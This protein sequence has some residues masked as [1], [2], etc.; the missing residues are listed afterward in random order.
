MKLRRVLA[1][2]AL[3]ASPAWADEPYYFHKAGIE[4]ET[5]AADVEYCA[6]LAGGASVARRTMYVY[7]PSIAISAVGSAI[8]SLFAGM[9]ARA[10]L[11][12]KVSR[13]ERTCMADKGYRRLALDKATGREMDKL[14]DLER[15]DRMFALVAAVT[16]S[17]KVL[18][19]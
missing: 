8:G 19:E 14:A 1:A 16:P 12:R 4:R 17:G 10:E 9:A 7:S 6:G 13:I 18:V 15:L 5:Y 2:S 11:R 3:V